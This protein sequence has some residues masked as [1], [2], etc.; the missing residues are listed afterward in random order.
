MYEM[1]SILRACDVMVSSRYH[2]M[3]TS[4]PA[5]VPAA[6]VTMDER[7]RNLLHEEGREDLLMTVD[8]PDLEDKLL[9][10]ME[11][12]RKDADAIRCA[13]GRAVVDNLKRMSRMGVFIEQN[14]HER[15]P[16]F[17]VRAGVRSWE[18]YLPPL[19][20]LLVGLVEKYESRVH[21]RAAG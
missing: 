7:I 9:M 19:S 12:L 2:G 17:P 3:V 13:M 6:G 18:E 21:A 8:D 5:L 15:Y 14:V 16:D 11:T 4:M 10:A 1:V 20:P